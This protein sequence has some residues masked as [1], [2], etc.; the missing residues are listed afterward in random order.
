MKTVLTLT[1]ILT[2]AATMPSAFA[3]DSGKTPSHAAL[4]EAL[5]GIVQGQ[6]GGFGLNMWATVVDRDGV[7]RAITFSG[8]DRGDQ[9]PGSRVIS[10]QKAHTANAFSLPKLALSTA[11]LYAAVQPGGALF[12]LA[13]SNPVSTEVAYAGPSGRYGLEKDPMVGRKAGGVNVFGGGLALY[14]ASGTLVGALGVSGLSTPSDHLSSPVWRSSR[15][16]RAAVRAQARSGASNT[17]RPATRGRRAPGGRRKR[18]I[19]QEGAVPMDAGQY[20]AHR[21]CVRST[22]G[23]HENAVTCA[24]AASGQAS[25]APG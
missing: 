16:L 24:P 19:S 8:K 14:D 9:W 7:V 11:Q 22:R 4:T 20:P 23:M 25:T 12:G 1:I 18:V 2:F 6:N 13:T 10:A 21:A 3:G 15:A 17:T 5:K